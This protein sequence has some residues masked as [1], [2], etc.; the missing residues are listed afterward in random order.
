MP[1][2]S[3]FQVALPFD[4]PVDQLEAIMRSFARIE[5][6][7]WGRQFTMPDVN[8]GRFYRLIEGDEELMVTFEYNAGPA[9]P[10]AFRGALASH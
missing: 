5:Q 7:K 8:P 2:P 6:T 9:N 10:N 3:R 4:P 1:Y